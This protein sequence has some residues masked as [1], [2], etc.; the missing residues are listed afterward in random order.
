MCVRLA[1]GAAVRRPPPTEAEKMEKTGHFWDQLIQQFSGLNFT[2][3]VPVIFSLVVIE[4]LLSVDNA[5][6][7]A[8]MAAHLPDRQKFLALRFGMIGAYVFRGLALASASLILKN[9][10]IKWFG[11]VYLLHLAADHFASKAE[12]ESQPLGGAE[13]AGRGFWATV[14]SIELM[15][16]SLSVDNVVAAVAMSSQLWAVCTGVFIGILALRFVAGYCIKLIEIFPILESAAFLLV[17][18]VG[19]ILVFELSTHM[20]VDSVQKFAGIVLILAASILYSRVPAVHRIL[21]PLV[22]SGR[23][24]FLLYAVLSRPVMRGVFWVVNLLCIAPLKWVWG[25]LRGP[26]RG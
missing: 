16:L 4:A 12:R 13:L 25:M 7:I 8:A 24:A 21:A 1:S 6:A 5:L 19:G 23:R 2:E 15:D 26:A 9:L 3:A 17:G 11:A 20:H 22:R 14:V 18:Y 10:W